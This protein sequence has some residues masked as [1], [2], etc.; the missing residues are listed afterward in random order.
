MSQRSP[1]PAVILAFAAILLLTGGGAWFILSRLPQTPAIGLPAPAPSATPRIVTGAAVIRQ[2]QALQ[3]LETTRYTVET[4]VEASTPDGWVSRGERLLLIAH[5]DVVAGFDLGKLRPEDVQ[6]SANG[7][8][9]T[10]TLPAAEILSA[11]LDEGKTRIYSRDSG[12][13]LGVFTRGADPN[14]ETEARRRG[15]QQIMASACEDGVL[16]RAG[17]DGTVAVRNLLTLAGYETVQVRT[18]DAAASACV[19]PR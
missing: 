13:Q 17:D 12:K 10:I 8:T 6:V 4:V 16:R 14:L 3:R 19:A 1:L 9:V 18:R 5:G 7:K 2:M 15:M 11:G